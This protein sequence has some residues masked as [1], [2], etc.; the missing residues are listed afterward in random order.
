MGCFPRFFKSRA[1]PELA[2]PPYSTL[3]HDARQQVVAKKASNSKQVFF[4][5]IVHSKS[6]KHLEIFKQAALGIDENGVI[7]FLDSSVDSAAA[8]CKKY[9]DFKEAHCTTLKPLEFL[10]PGM[11]DTHMH[12]PQWPNMA[13]GMEGN[14]K[15]WVEGY[16]DPIEHSYKDTNKARRVYD[17][18][19]QKL[20]ENGTTMAAYNSSPHWE[21]TNVLADMCLKYGQRAIVGKLCMDCNSTHGNIEKT[22]QSL[23]DEWKSVEHIRKID[24]EETLVS[25][26][27]QPRNGAFATPPLMA[28]LGKMSNGK[29]GSKKIHIQ[30][31]MC[32]TLYDINQMKKLHSGS[33]NYSEM[34][35]SYGFL[36]EKTILAHC[37][38]LSDRDIELLAE[39]KA[40]VAHN[41][42]S[43]TC[44]TDGE[45][46]VRELL[47]AGVK[48]GLGTDC[49]A[50]YGVSI[51]ESMRAASN[52]S[53]HLV[54]HKDDP[55]LKLN[56]EEIVYLGTMGGAQVCAMD[57]KIGN[58]ET[59]KPFDALVIDVGQKDNINIAG[60][61]G[62]DL[63]LVKKW[64][65][66]GDDRSIRKVF[67]N[68]RLVAGKDM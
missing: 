32:E 52:V 42:N 65:F 44:L 34:Y 40:G 19:V 27:I 67:V 51:L 5:R 9:P 21:A 11:I 54:I 31:H 46:R 13:I 39:R 22:E 37:I 47:N 4:G 7:C 10:F 58:F 55:S 50:G 53:R 49:S 20:L 64:V 57:D 45:C 14:L 30:A 3:D 12:A 56:F 66:M 48:V 35:D 59:G 16:T 63:A 24:P 8:A 61:E 17:E 62:D 15:E 6:L 1:K 36:H 18:M 23:E 25:P 68:G 2:P 26:C 33:K 38:H 29:P 60:W 41:G 28:G 43:N